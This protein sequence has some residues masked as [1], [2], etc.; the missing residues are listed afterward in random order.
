MPPSLSI[1]I[2][3][4]NEEDGIA[5][6]LAAATA[7]LEEIGSDWEILIVDNASTDRTC[8]RVEPFVDGVR[9]RL[10]RN[11]LNRGKG[12]S[13][14]RGMLEARGDLR[15]MCDADCVASLR[16]LP[17]MMKVAEEVD[18]VMGSRVVGGAEVSHQQP[19]RR[20]VV[21]LGF[22]LLTRVL[23][24]RLARDVYCGFKL[25]R[26]EPA[27]EVFERV[28]LEGWVF[29]AEALAIAQS[30]GYSSREVGIEWANRADSRLSIGQVLLP[31]IHELLAA[32]RNIRRQATLVRAARALLP[33]GEL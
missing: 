16:S 6:M 23:I 14:R 3:V 32:R 7:Q 18:V 33:S 11:E 17:D 28:R 24:G 12:F 31:V 5:R 29:D 27:Q 19:L 8:E 10:L 30:L 20:R 9:V 15:L 4:L 13:V 22:L 21:G 25:W 26:A 2:P 1:V